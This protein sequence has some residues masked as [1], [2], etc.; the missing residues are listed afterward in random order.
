MRQGP[1]SPND[2]DTVLRLVSDGMTNAAIGEIIGRTEKSVCAR[3]SKIRPKGMERRGSYHRYTPD[4]DA[5]IV[6]LRNANHRFADIGADLGL[7]GGQVRERYLLL[8]NGS[9]YKAFQNTPEGFEARD[10]EYVEACIRQGGFIHR[11]VIDGCVFTFDWRGMV[12]HER[13]A[14]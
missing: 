6:T 8:C 13:R 2:D 12:S 10:D 3:L 11:E 14:A 1:Y 9:D 4:E 7:T 5:Q